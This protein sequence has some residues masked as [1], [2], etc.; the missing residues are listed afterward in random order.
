MKIRILQ[1]LCPSR[2]CL[3]AAVYESQDGEPKP[4]MMAQLAE[5]V[6]DHGV[7]LVC[8][9]CGSADVGFED[10]VTVFTSMEQARPEFERL[11]TMNL[12]TGEA[13]RRARAAGK[14]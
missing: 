6:A 3:A 1:L 2:H 14:N 9:I 11:Q 5:Q 7:S 13:I 8:G 10:A 12:L 4:G